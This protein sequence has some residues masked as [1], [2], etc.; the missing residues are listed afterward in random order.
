[1]TPREPDFE[2]ICWPTAIGVQFLKPLLQ[3]HLFRLPLVFIPVQAMLVVLVVM[4]PLLLGMR[5]GVAFASVA[6]FD[7]HVD[8][9]HMAIRAAV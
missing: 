2:N 1:M 7:L 3:H 5:Y 8:T 9:V 6:L 4:F